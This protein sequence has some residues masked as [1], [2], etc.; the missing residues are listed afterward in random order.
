MLDC[1]QSQAVLLS[2]S[3]NHSSVGS[4]G[5]IGE[6]TYVPDDFH[7][8]FFLIIH[9]PAFLPKSISTYFFL[10]STCSSSFS[11]SLS[12]S[13]SL[14][15]PLSL[16][17]SLYLSLSL[18]IS[19]SVIPVLSLPLPLSLSLSLWLPLTLSVSLYLITYYVYTYCISLPLVF[20]GRRYG[21][22][23]CWWWNRQRQST[24]RSH[25]Y[26][27]SDLELSSLSSSRHW[28][29]HHIR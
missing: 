11:L 10:Y 4:L 7:M 5:S 3:T 20:P 19:L 12:L 17:L 28:W 15:L 23:R 27:Q 18:F 13:H 2:H 9:L 8:A 26:Y 14:S 24:Q 16:S 29:R 1:R 21:S 6:V 22:W 25:R